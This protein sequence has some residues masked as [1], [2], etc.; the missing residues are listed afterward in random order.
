MGHYA[1]VKWFC[2]LMCHHELEFSA[3]DIYGLGAIAMVDTHSAAGV[4][5]LHMDL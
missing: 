4:P 1:G 3:L 2:T 5:F